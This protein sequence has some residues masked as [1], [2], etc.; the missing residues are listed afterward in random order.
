[1]RDRIPT[2]WLV[3]LA[4]SLL[5]SPGSLCAQESPNAD[6]SFE[7]EPPWLVQPTDDKKG[8]NEKPEAPPDAAK[9]TQQLE[10]AK[11]SAASVERLVK[12]GA[13]A[14]IDGEQRAL[15][16]IR[17]E[18][19]LARAQV[20]AAQAEAAAQQTRHAAGQTSKAVL[21]A[22]TTTLT[23]ASAAAQAAE[24]RYR[25]AQLDAAALNLHRQQRLFALGAARK[26][27]VTRAEEKLATLQR[28]EK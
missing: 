8:V 25:K 10:Q 23:A 26:S 7:V 15:R 19:E 9:L 22:A 6:E 2:G 4:A 11:K 21:D 14:K 3:V 12:I 24:E 27:D 1:M 28:A 16:V 13:L 5:L 20:V 18:S 17:L